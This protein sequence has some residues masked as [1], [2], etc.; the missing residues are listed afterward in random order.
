[1][2]TIVYDDGGLLVLF[3]RK[4]CVKVLGLAVQL[5]YGLVLRALLQSW[6][7]FSV[8]AALVL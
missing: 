4:I 8:S 5:L 7:F 6:I 3:L 2:E 1:M